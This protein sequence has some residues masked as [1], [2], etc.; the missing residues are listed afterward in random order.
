VP[1]AEQAQARSALFVSA[2]FDLTAI[3]ISF[4]P[5]ATLNARRL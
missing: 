2:K 5:A 4:N 1:G 3:A